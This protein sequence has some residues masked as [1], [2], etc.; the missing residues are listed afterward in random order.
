MMGLVMNTLV[1]HAG[2]PVELPNA[3]S[4]LIARAQKV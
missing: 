4:E 1:L 3:D 2:G